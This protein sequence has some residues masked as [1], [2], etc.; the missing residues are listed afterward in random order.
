MLAR[1]GNIVSA[2]AGDRNAKRQRTCLG[3]GR[4]F[5]SDNVGHRVCSPCKASPLWANRL[6]AETIDC[7][8]RVPAASRNN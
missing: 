2:P 7:G 4:S 5:D 3:C 1:R 8:R 6:G